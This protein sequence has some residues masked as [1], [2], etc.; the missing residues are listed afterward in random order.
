MN[1]ILSHSLTWSHLY[2]GYRGPASPNW[3][4]WGLA[5]N[6]RSQNIKLGVSAQ[7]SEPLSSCPQLCPPTS[8]LVPWFWFIWFPSLP[9]LISSCFSRFV[10]LFLFLLFLTHFSPLEPGRPPPPVSSSSPLFV[11]PPSIQ[12][13]AFF[14]RQPPE[15][16]AYFTG[17]GFSLPLR[18]EKLAKWQARAILQIKFL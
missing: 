2:K 5:Q 4:S 13:L 15:P 6:S 8:F 10:L 1:S 7:H 18:F 14:G 12:R 16:K 3:N 11:A 17:G 9:K